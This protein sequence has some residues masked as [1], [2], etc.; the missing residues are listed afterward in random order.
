ML[1]ADVTGG[2]VPEP[3]CIVLLL[4]SLAGLVETLHR[5]TNRSQ[6]S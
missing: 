5:R 6:T 4:N 2:A 3:S 1:T